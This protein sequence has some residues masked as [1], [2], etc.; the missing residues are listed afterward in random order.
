MKLNTSYLY[1][2]GLLVWSLSLFLFTLTLPLPIALKILLASLSLFLGWNS[3]RLAREAKFDFELPM[4]QVG[5]VLALCFIVYWGFFILGHNFVGD[6]GKHRAVLMGLFQSPFSPTLSGFNLPEHDAI[7]HSTLVYYYLPYL[8]P[9][10]ISKALNLGLQYQG[11]HLIKFV[12]GVYAAW[13]FVLLGWGLLF[14]GP[15][16]SKLVERTSR[17]AI[18]YFVLL[19][20]IWG[21]GDFWW[22]QMTGIPDLVFGHHIDGYFKGIYKGQ[23]HGFVS[24]AAW[25]PSQLCAIL[26]AFAIMGPFQNI[27]K[28]PWALWCAVI[29]FSAP[30]GAIGFIPILLLLLYR[31]KFNFSALKDISFLREVVTA[32]V[33]L[34]IGLWFFGSRIEKDPIILSKSFDEGFIQYFSFLTRE[35]LFVLALGVWAYYR[36]FWKPHMLVWLFV[37]LLWFTP[38]YMGEFNAWMFKVSMPMTILGCYLWADLLSRETPGARWNLLILGVVWM[39]PLAIYETYFAIK[40]KHIYIED[41][42]F[43]IIQYSGRF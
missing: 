1:R 38:L 21:G 16:F 9:V 15:F 39:M 22:S 7:R 29:F 19:L 4:K 17:Q 27:Q 31:E 2:S 43:L 33:F 37:S 10:W 3:D 26:A 5:I 13:N 28:T 41:L 18:L 32:I 6:W 35:Y 34:L 20:F 40:A 24:L 42:R 25:V 14:A 8:I 36:K 30:M 11:D 12:T 23:I